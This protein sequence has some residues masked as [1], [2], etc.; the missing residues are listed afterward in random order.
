MSTSEILTIGSVIRHRGSYNANT[1]YYINNQ[2]TM[3][4][5]VFQAIGNNFSGVP[6]IEENSD[7]TIKLANTVTWKCIVDNT[8]LYNAALSTNNLDSRLTAAEESVKEVKETADTFSDFVNSKG[9]TNGIAPLDENTQVPSKYLPNSVNDVLEFDTTVEGVTAMAASTSEFTGIA[10]DT[11]VKRFYAYI[12][13]AGLIQQITY[14]KNWTDG[15]KYQDEITGIPFTGKIY[16]NTSS[17]TLYRWTG[18]GLE[19]VGEKKQVIIFD[20][21]V[22]GVT[23]TAASTTSIDGVVYDKEVK[24]FCAYQMGGTTLVPTVTYYK[25]WP[26]RL[27]YENIE[28]DTPHKERIYVNM[29]DYSP[30]IWNGTEMKSL[31]TK[32]VALTQDEYNALVAAGIVDENTYYNILED[33]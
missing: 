33:E 22:S 26:T 29:S 13:N 30:Y 4:N 20:R 14:Y 27:D 17:D 25:N 16:M 24:R 3:C 5:C 23:M 6:P 2:V 11:A 28:T 9:S 15:N 32:A 21:V 1:I 19:R 31:G 12:V 10:Y 18:S 8:A 7:G